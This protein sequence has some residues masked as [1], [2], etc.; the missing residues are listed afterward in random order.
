[1]K[2]NREQL[3]RMLTIVQPGLASKEIVEQSSSFIFRKGFVHSYND[4]LYVQAPLPTKGL[5]GA[6][7]AE[8]LLTLLDRMEDDEVELEM[9]KGELLISGKRTKAGVRMDAEV[10]LPVDKFINL[11]GAWKKVPKGLVEG[12]AT[13]YQYATNSLARPE[14]TAVHV[15]ETFV[16][17]C[18]GFQMVRVPCGKVSKELLIPAHVISELIEYPVTQYMVGKD[19]WF[20]LRTE[21]KVGI[22]TRQTKT[23]DKYPDL[24]PFLKRTKDMKQVRFPSTLLQSVERAKIFSIAEF[25]QDER[26]L[27][28]FAGGKLVI[29]AQSEKG[30]V[31]ETLRTRFKDTLQFQVQ[32]ELLLMV[33]DKSNEVLVGTDRML[34][35]HDDATY[36][37]SLFK[38]EDE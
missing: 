36:A 30:W 3:W 14:L 19:G 27:V 6:V 26:V 5:E 11:K 31:E 9:G 29:R 23:N 35:Q 22:G 13:S 33:V 8:E 24:A 20:H 34:V 18:D 7:P 4:L 17:A 28:K 32:P 25:K 15:K 16:E 21:E 1:M 10:T 38:D 37:I 2:V 12:L